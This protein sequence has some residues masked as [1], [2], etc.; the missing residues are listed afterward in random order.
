[1]ITRDSQENY[2]LEQASIAARSAESSRFAARGSNKDLAPARKSEHSR[3]TRR[4]Q[5]VKF[6]AKVAVTAA[7]M[8]GGGYVLHEAREGSTITI[9][10]E[11]Q[12][13]NV[14]NVGSTVTVGT[15]TKAHEVKPTN[16]STIAELAYPGKDY[17][18]LATAL[19][20]EVVS[21]NEAHHYDGEPGTLQDGTPLI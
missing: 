1:M 3:L 15:G 16:L 19:Q 17:R 14:F 12:E 4:G 11:T 9:P 6:G 7:I 5:L 21:Y 13:H 20:S 18:D 8:G 10:T 2:R